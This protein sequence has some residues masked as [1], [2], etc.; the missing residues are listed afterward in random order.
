MEPTVDHD[1]DRT[2][3]HCLL[4]E[5]LKAASS[6]HVMLLVHCCVVQEI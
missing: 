4:V 5:F 3:S 1:H 6:G 2:H